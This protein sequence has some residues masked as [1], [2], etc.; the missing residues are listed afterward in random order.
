M[1]KLV[2]YVVC[3]VGAIYA[4][5]GTLA[6]MAGLVATVGGFDVPI[7]WCGLIEVTLMGYAVAYYSGMWLA[8]DN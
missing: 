2:N 5:M 4:L 3:V 7:R 6:L 8:R 1:A